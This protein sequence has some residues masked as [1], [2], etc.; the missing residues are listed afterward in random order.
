MLPTYERS[1]YNYHI[2]DS[3][4]NILDC[5]RINV[6]GNAYMIMLFIHFHFHFPL[7][8]FRLLKHSM[9]N[10]AYAQFLN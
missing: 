1:S 7:H 6:S 5:C 3:Y 9:Y 10:V 8:I 4:R 2:A